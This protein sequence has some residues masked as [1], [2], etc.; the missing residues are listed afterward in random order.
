MQALRK[1]RSRSVTAASG[2]AKRFSASSLDVAVFEDAAAGGSAIPD[3]EA[4]AELERSFQRSD[5]A[6]L[7]VVGQFNLGFIS[8]CHDVHPSSGL[9]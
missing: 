7:R 9:G 8:E 3:D 1:D 2:A 6:S 4:T 5:F